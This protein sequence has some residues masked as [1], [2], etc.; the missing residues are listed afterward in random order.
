LGSDVPF[1]KGDRCPVCGRPID[2][3]ERRVVKGNGTEHVY[4]YARHIVVDENGQKKVK[5]CYLGAET[6]DY[7]SRKNYDLGIVFMGMAV[8]PVMRLTEYV[9]SAVSRLNVRIEGGTLDPERAKSWLNAL[10]EATAKLQTLV[11]ALEKYVREHG[12]KEAEAQ[13]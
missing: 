11:D 2:Y 4:Y 6:Y 9:N 12:S 1:K 10:R 7:V 5:K 8:D 3:I 13:A